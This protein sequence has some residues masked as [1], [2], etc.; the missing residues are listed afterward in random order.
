[1]KVVEFKGKKPTPTYQEMLLQHLDECDE[2]LRNQ[3]IE[4]MAIVINT[5][6]SG[7]GVVPLTNS[8]IFF[9][10]GMMEACKVTLI[11]LEMGVED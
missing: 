7:V 9:L 2:E 3:R 10:I 8:N 1:M 4:D 11:D 5:L 6:D